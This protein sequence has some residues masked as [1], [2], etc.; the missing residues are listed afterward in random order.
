MGTGNDSAG[1]PG[2]QLLKSNIDSGILQILTHPDI[3]VYA[4]VYELI[5]LLAKNR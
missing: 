5:Q 4:G 3:P 1:I 2:L